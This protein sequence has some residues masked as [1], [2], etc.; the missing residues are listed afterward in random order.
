[1]A[2]PVQSESASRVEGPSSVP[3]DLPVFAADGK[4]VIVALDHALAGGQLPSLDRP[5]DLI[6]R[7]SGGAPDGLILTVGMSRVRGTT[8]APWLLTADYYATSV[9]P[10]GSGEDD[11][12]TLAW[13]DEAANALGACGLKCLLVFG[14]RDPRQLEVNVTRVAALV[15]KA[16]R[17]GLPVMI[18]AT[19]WGARISATQQHDATMI[20]HAARVAF[21]LGA[22]VIKIPLPDDAEALAR[23][24]DALPVPIVIMGGAAGRA[25]ELFFHVERALRAGVR[26]VAMG[27]NV[28]QA[29]DPAAYIAALRSMVHGGAT[30][31]D[32]VESVRAG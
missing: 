23:L 31:A 25:D 13:D 6:E 5:A 15:T 11:V 24:T 3:L 9:F 20:C 14:R 29:R 27:R 2:R 8:R 1:M 19:L 26:G 10:G 22:D 30:A 32:A 4:S 12:H 17:A 16:H 21:E 7:I 28:W 18:E